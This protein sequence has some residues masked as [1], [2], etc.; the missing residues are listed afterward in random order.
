[1]WLSRARQEHCS[2]STDS[3][4][5][6]A[7]RSWSCACVS[8][9]RG[10]RQHGADRTEDGGAGDAVGGGGREGPTSADVLAK[11]DRIAA[12]VPYRPFEEPMILPLGNPHSYHG[13]GIAE[14][15]VGGAGGQVAR[16][17]AHFPP[18][19]TDDPS[20]R[21]VPADA[22]FENQNSWCHFSLHSAHAC[23]SDSRL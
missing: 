13:P 3:W 17:S 11:L 9:C 14:S 22:R 20:H 10:Q 23:F 2:S 5:K 4:M 7:C 12:M 1:M 19:L 8:R 15:G 6:P 18:Q 21:C 16:D